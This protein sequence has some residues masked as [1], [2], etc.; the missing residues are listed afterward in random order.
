[1]DKNTFN[2]FIPPF[3]FKHYDYVNLVN[4]SGG[5]WVLWNNT[6]IM[7]QVLLKEPRCIHMLV[8]DGMT[9]TLT[10][11]SNIYMLRHN[12]LINHYFSNIS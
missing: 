7:A 6:N 3:G 4:H 8:L 10:T 12:Q 9:Q 2:K 1:M 11:I 5:L